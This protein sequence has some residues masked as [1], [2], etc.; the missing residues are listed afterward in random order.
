MTPP[1]RMFNEKLRLNSAPQ[2]SDQ[3]TTEGGRHERGDD[4]PFPRCNSSGVDGGT[5]PSCHG[6]STEDNRRDQ[7][8]CE[9]N[10][11]LK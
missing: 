10:G 6:T 5:R 9:G 3:F 1:W 11:A 8:M 2:D 7:S 4:V